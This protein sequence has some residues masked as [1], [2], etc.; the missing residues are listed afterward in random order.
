MILFVK[1]FFF[2]TPN[3]LDLPGS[4]FL[5]IFPKTWEP[6]NKLEE[7]RRA[8]LERLLMESVKEGWRQNQ[9]KV[10]TSSDWC[11]F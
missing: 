2:P 8:I 5:F 1:G 11:E 9:W 10:D 6:E 4:D 3:I 7:V